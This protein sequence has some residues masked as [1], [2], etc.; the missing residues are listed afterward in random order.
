MLQQDICQTGEQYS[1]LVG[2]PVA[3]TGAVCQQPHLL[4]F[5]PVFHITTDTIDLIV[6]VLRLPLEAGHNETYIFTAIAI[7]GFGYDSPRSAPTLCT[8]LKMVKLSLLLP[9]VFVEPF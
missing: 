3:G 8:I 7:L 1:P 2:P 4:L 6:E 9:R 5:D